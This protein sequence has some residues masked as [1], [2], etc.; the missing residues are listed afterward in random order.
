M[1]GT[2]NDPYANY[3]FLVEIDGLLVGGFSEVSGLQVETEVEEYREG[4][5]NDTVHKFPK[6]SK[7]S[8]ITLKRGITDS[9]TL[10][11]WH[12]SVVQGNF[13]RHTGRIILTDTLGNEK[14]HWLFVDAYPIKW[15]GPDLSSDGSA[16]AVETLELVQQGL[17]K[18]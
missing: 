10:W 15:V 6:G 12:Q 17:T 3:C 11:N 4:G 8:N 9:D 14:W 1:S 7:Q 13:D 5:L 16:T 2:R 18:G